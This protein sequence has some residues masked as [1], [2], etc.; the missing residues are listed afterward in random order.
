MK[1]YEG[2]YILGFGCLSDFYFV[3][4]ILNDYETLEIAEGSPNSLLYKFKSDMKA[5]NMFNKFDLT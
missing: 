1:M 2:N 3:N 5:K 4:I